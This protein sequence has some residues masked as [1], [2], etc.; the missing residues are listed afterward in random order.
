MAR[1]DIDE[2]KRTS[3]KALGVATVTALAGGTLG[4]AAWVDARNRPHPDSSKEPTNDYIDDVENIEGL[5]RFED[6]NECV[7]YDAA[8]ADR[9]EIEEFAS[10]YDN[11]GILIEEASSGNYH[12]TF[13]ELENSDELVKD[14]K[15]NYGKDNLELDEGCLEGL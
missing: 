15:L 1:K 13:Y 12:G 7:N 11:L 5:Y 14:T 4:T 3:W 8:N 9:D 2:A 10:E 6:F